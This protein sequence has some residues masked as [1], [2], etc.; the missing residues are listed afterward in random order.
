MPSEQGHIINV[1]NLKKARDYAVSLG[2]S[3]QPSH[4]D[5]LVPA[6]NTLIAS[7]EATEQGASPKS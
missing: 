1:S 2:A 3:Y 7:A 6:I 5:L 4:P